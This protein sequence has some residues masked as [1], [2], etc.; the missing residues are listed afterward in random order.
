M[1]SSYRGWAWQSHF[2]KGE[3]SNHQSLIL[4][5]KPGRRLTLATFQ[6]IWNRILD[7]IQIDFFPKII[8]DLMRNFRPASATIFALS[9]GQ[10]PGQPILSILN[11]TPL[12]SSS[13][14]F[15]PST[16]SE[17]IFPSPLSKRPLC[18]VVSNCLVAVLTVQCLPTHETFQIGYFKEAVVHTWMLHCSWNFLSWERRRNCDSWYDV[19]LPMKHSRLQIWERLWFIYSISLIMDYSELFVWKA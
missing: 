5:L 16:I 9:S 19:S 7:S 1:R 14:T 10:L 6:E 3:A 11:P 2:G 13:L 17:C 18:K 15:I 12:P 4:I 8:W